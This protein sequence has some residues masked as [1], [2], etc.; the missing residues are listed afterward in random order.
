MRVLLQ[1]L[2]FPSKTSSSDCHASSDSCTATSHGE[3][4]CLTGNGKVLTRISAAK[5]LR[6]K[7]EKL[8]LD[9]GADR[10][11]KEIVSDLKSSQI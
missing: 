9:S 3:R 8:A 10:V 5:T 1:V 11:V 6:D 7:A 4:A 2:L